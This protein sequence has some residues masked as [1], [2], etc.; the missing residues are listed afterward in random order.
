MTVL[1]RKGEFAGELHPWG[2]RRPGAE[3]DHLNRAVRKPSLETGGITHIGHSRATRG[4]TVVGWTSM[5]RR[6]RAT[7]SERN[8]RD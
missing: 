6:A 3:I 7:G 1:G 4:G 5:R 8:I 2:G